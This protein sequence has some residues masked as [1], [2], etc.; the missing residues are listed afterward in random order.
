MKTFVRSLL[1]RFPVLRLVLPQRLVFC[2]MV[3]LAMNLRFLA[4]WRQ[5]RSAFRP[6]HPGRL[7]PEV[8]AAVR[9]LRIDG[10]TV[11]PPPRD[12][13]L[14]EAVAS[15]VSALVKA[16][17]TVVD[18]TAEDWMVQVRDSMAAV[19]DAV[20]LLQPEIASTIED[21][22]QSHFKIYCAEIYRLT[23]TDQAPRLS[24][25]WHIDNYP[26]GMLKVFIYLTD[27][28]RKTGA[29]RLLPRNLSRR[30]FRQGFFDRH[31][32]ERFVEQL[33]RDGFPVEGKA[34]TVIVW[35][36]NLIHRAKAPEYGF[37]DAVSIKVL[38]SREFW[39][40]HA[41]RM[42]SALSYER[43]DRQYPKDPA[44]D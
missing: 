10:F 1:Q 38:P 15:R 6:D 22:Y 24:S 43:R 39:G 3:P 35:D 23:V 19:P 34:G 33:E 44:V 26:P 5:C 40:R 2:N 21:Y 41:A 29:L 31:C 42:G 7:S 4:H 32:A 27:C 16:G 28:D 37:R 20:R 14:T 12:L 8:Q 25:L 18:H 36:Q 17:E 9:R 13:S 30:L 11:F